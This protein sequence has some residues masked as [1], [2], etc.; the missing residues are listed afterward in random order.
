MINGIA[1]RGR[2]LPGSLAALHHYPSSQ[3]ELYPLILGSSPMFGSLS[4]WPLGQGL[5]RKLKKP[6]SSGRNAGS[7]PTIPR[8][9]LDIREANAM[10]QLA[11]CVIKWRLVST[12]SD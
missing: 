10:R 12:A 8:K 1:D 2:D 11:N 7:I 4:I 3:S 6:F 5:C 9:G